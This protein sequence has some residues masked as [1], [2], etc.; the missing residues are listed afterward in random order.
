MKVFQAHKGEM[1]FIQVI[2]PCVAWEEHRDAIRLPKKLWMTP[3]WRPHWMRAWAA[4]SSGWQAH[5]RGT[6]I[7]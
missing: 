1:P 5:G 2:A 6:E 7:G 4:S 3:S